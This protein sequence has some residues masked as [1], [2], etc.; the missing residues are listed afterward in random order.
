[1]SEDC[2]VVLNYA[3]CQLELYISIYGAINIPVT[4]N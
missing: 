2:G 3:G 4:C 1:M